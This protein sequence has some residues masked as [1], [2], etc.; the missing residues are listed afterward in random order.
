MQFD[1]THAIISA[2]LIFLT[3]FVMRKTGLADPSKEKTFE[4]KIFLGVFVVMFVLNVIW[5][6]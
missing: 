4:W 2:V 5:P 3:I 6:Y 1:L